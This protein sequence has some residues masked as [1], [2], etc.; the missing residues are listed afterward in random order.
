V[1]GIPEADS[2]ERECLI[3]GKENGCEEDY[4]HADL[5][6]GLRAEVEVFPR[7]AEWLERQDGNPGSWRE[8]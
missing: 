2:A 4:G 3:L 1:K 6:V 7:V 5:V 8:K